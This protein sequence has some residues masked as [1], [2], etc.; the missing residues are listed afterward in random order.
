MMWGDWVKQ[1]NENGNSTGQYKSNRD[2]V[3]LQE[4]EQRHVDE[5]G[6]SKRPRW[7]SECYW[8]TAYEILASV[9]NTVATAAASRYLIELGFSLSFKVFPVNFTLWRPEHSD[10]GFFSLVT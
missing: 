2:A 10:T 4:R 1:P 8:F 9:D 5:K 3:L 6:S 7:N